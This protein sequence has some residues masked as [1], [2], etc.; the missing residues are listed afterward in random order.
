MFKYQD[1]QQLLTINTKR[2]TMHK[3]LHKYKLA[4][5]CISVSKWYASAAYCSFKTK[6]FQSVL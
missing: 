6:Y 1:I 5:S 2:N 4:E 3:V